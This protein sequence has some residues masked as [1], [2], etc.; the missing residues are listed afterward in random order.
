M[1]TIAF[2]LIGHNEAHNLP[3]ALES[4][5]DGHGGTMLRWVFDGSAGIN[6]G[7]TH[8]RGGSW[9]DLI[10]NLNGADWSGYKAIKFDI[11]TTR[12]GGSVRDYFRVD[13]KL[14]EVGTE[15]GNYFNDDE[16]WSAHKLDVG[17][18]GA[19]IPGNKHSWLGG[20]EDS[21]GTDV[22]VGIECP[23]GIWPQPEFEAERTGWSTFELNF[24]QI[25]D[26]RGGF[27]ANPGQYDCGNDWDYGED[28]C[29]ED[30]SSGFDGIIELDT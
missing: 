15:P 12:P 21:G 23:D 6:P 5:S 27:W 7:S 16:V 24:N 30:R 13:A 29:G 18:D 9:F 20:C 28:V 22:C 25:K 26:S 8:P 11:A 10:L 19:A 17:H 2:T 14:D 1:P 3:R 4:V